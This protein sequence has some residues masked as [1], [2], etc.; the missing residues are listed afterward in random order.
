LPEIELP[1]SYRW[2]EIARWAK[3]ITGKSRRAF[4][5]RK[6]AKLKAAHP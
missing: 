5:E 6:L 4:V 1:R 2:A 3:K